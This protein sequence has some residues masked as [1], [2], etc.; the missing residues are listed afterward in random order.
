MG[1]SPEKIRTWQTLSCRGSKHSFC[2]S[3][4]WSSFHWDE[5]TSK[6]WGYGKSAWQCP[7]RHDKEIFCCLGIPWALA[8][9]M[10]DDGEGGW[11]SKAKGTRNFF[12]AA[13]PLG[14]PCSRKWFAPSDYL[15]QWRVGYFLEESTAEPSNDSRIETDDQEFYPQPAANTICIAWGWGPFHRNW[16]CASLEFQM[17]A[18]KKIG[19]WVPAVDY[20]CTKASN[21]PVDFPTS[22]GSCGLV[23]QNSFWRSVPKER[24]TRQADRN[25]QRQEIEKRSALEHH[26]RLRMVLPRVS[27]SLPFFQHDVPLLPSWPEEGAH[28]ASLH[29]F[30]TWCHLE[31]DHFPQRRAQEEVCQAPFVESTCSDHPVCEAGLA[32]HNWLGSSCLPA[33]FFALQHHGG[34]AWHK[35][36]LG[37]RRPLKKKN[38][39]AG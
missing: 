35:Q 33:W 6:P 5:R 1:A 12:D 28:Q 38:M 8:D 29:R 20:S 15:H 18:L 7:Q 32:T 3:E 19:F 30:S 26:R 34:A 31:R 23:F 13:P 17:F 16:F 22:D 4:E 10:R 21:G 27:I 36:I 9:E 24:F 37:K 11:T 25:T 39:W 2:S 14:A